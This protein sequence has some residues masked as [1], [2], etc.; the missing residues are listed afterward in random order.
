MINVFPKITKSFIL[1]RITE[2]EIMERYLGLKV[3][4]N[5]LYKSPLRVD[6]HPT[7][8]YTYWNGRLYFKDFNGSFN[9]D[10]FNVVQ[11]IHSTNFLD[12]LY[13]IANDFNI[14]K[15]PKKELVEYIFDKPPVQE[16][17]SIGIKS[18]PFTDIDKQYWDSYFISEQSL[19]KYFVYSCKQ[20]FIGEN[21]IYNYS[22]KDPAYAYY[23]G[24]GN[25]KIYFPFRKK[26]E[27]RF[28]NNCNNTIIQGYWQLPKENNLL[29]I[30][31]SYKDVICLSE[32]NIHSIAPQ[33]ETCGLTH[34]LI[35]E[36]SQRFKTIISL[37]DFD[38]TGIRGANKLYKEENIK[39]IFFT[40]GRF[41]S[42][43][44][45]AKDFSD[46]LHDNGFLKTKELVDG[47]LT[48]KL[49]N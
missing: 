21:I 27:K 13:I 26:E 2:I 16:K 38:L 33:S 37:Y 36:L 17:L 22:K 7:C 49:I 9:G 48:Q 34:G 32:F 29:I 4:T 41:N 15:K 24:N 25:Y 3:D 19:E 18:Q 6:K 5:K 11:K 44:Y 20:V 45:Q 43:D 35:R 30:T 1:N 28:I 8:K 23:F 47:L 42:I 40:N 14:L 12:S 39:P 31:K 10:C 46:Y